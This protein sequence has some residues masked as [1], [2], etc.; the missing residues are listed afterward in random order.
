MAY[1]CTCFLCFY[2]SNRCPFGIRSAA[3][4]FQRNMESLLKS[5][6]HTVVFQD[7]I[8]VSGQNIVEH[9]QNLEEV[10]R[11]LNR[12]GLRLKCSKCVFLAPEM[13]FL[14]RRIA[15]DGIR[16]TNAKTEAIENA[17]RP[18][19]VTELRSFL[20]LLNY[21]EEAIDDEAH[22]EANGWGATSPSDITEMAE[23]VLTLVGKHPRTATDASADPEVMPPQPA[24]WPQAR[25]QRP[26]G[27][28]AGPD[29]PDDPTSGAEELRFSPVNPLGVCSPR[30]RVQTS[31]NLHRHAPEAIPPQGHLV[32]LRSF[33]PPLRR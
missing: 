2:V 11:R 30:M 33:P 20:R 29:S 21:F 25:P 12:M 31:R 4:I 13:A 24:A 10:V 9:L 32:V 17:P 15:A 16:P 8:L 7:Y 14:G 28:G 5:V 19:N 3:A 6:S 1:S 26:E 27:G 23:R 18:Q 22:E